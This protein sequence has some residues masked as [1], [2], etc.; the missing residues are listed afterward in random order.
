MHACVCVCVC[1]QALVYHEAPPLTGTV[2]DS[3][4]G[5]DDH[6]PIWMFL[7]SSMVVAVLFA[8][9]CNKQHLSHKPT[10]SYTTHNTLTLRP[11]FILY[12]T[13]TP[14]INPVS[15]HTYYCAI[16]EKC[17]CTI[18]GAGAREYPHIT[19]APHTTLTSPSH[20]PYTSHYPH[21]T[22]TP[23]TTLTSPSHHPHITLTPPT[24][25]TSPSHHPHITLTPPTTLTS[26]SHLPLPS[27]YP[28]TS[29]YPHITL[30]P[31]TI[32]S[33]HPHTSHYPHIA[34]TP[35]LLCSVANNY[36]NFTLESCDFSSN[37]EPTLLGLGL[38]LALVFTHCTPNDPFGGNPGQPSTLPPHHPHTS[39]YPHITLTPHT[40][41]CTL[42]LW[43]APLS[44][45]HSG[46]LWPAPLIQCT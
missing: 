33:H 2:P 22:L 45:A 10:H 19:L 21:I 38:G 20:P 42:L 23:P 44:S 13:L 8:L 6:R 1:V 27:H 29:H 28:H 34:T 17:S 35:P 31:H 15:P 32:S 24:T 3:K 43:P 7:H 18:L 25:L 14:H 9:Q 30:T 26:P 37:L 4:A 46:P 16:T 12:S 5:T 41:S 11:A 36:P 39:H 40:P